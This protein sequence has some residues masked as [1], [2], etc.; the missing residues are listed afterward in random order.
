MLAATTSPEHFARDVDVLAP[1]I[2]APPYQDTSHHRQLS[3]WSRLYWTA[4]LHEIAARFAPPTE[5]NRSAWVDL[6]ARLH[7]VTGWTIEAVSAPSEEEY[8]ALAESRDQEDEDFDAAMRR[9][10]RDR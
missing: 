1:P 9:R 6:F 10:V 3:A 8:A 2:S 7:E 5:G 4:N